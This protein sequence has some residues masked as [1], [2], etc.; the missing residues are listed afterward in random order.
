MS[1]ANVET[2]Q[3]TREEAA[4]A[5]AKYRAA[6]RTC[7]EHPFGAEDEVIIKA[8]RALARGRPVIDLRDAIRAGGVHEDGL[9]KFAVCRADARECHVRV[10]NDG[11]VCFASTLAHATPYVRATFLNRPLFPTDTLPRPTKTWPRGHTLVPL[12]PAPL[13]PPNALRGYLTL[14]EVERWLPMPPGDPFLLKWLGSGFLC[15]IVAVWNLTP[16]ER[17][18]MRNSVIR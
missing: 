5:L 3:S 1:L 2:I 15:A 9:P 18:V 12:V 16:L 11:S 17:A 6:M 8:Y 13:R 4:E 14:W 7:G 10:E